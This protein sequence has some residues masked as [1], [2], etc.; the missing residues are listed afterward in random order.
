MTIV[1]LEISPDPAPGPH[2]YDKYP[3][4]L[5]C[6]LLMDLAGEL[7]DISKLFF[8]I[9]DIVY[10]KEREI[11]V[12]P[13]ADLAEIAKIIQASLARILSEIQS[14]NY[15]AFFRFASLL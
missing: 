2:A 15:K 3:G 8:I 6:R 13:P 10:L 11:R 1:I 9:S 14:E 5:H 4:H 7:S 12:L